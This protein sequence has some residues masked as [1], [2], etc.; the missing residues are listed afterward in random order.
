MTAQAVLAPT[1]LA[2]LTS[3]AIAHDGKVIPDDLTVDGLI[4]EL[5][6]QIQAVNKKDLVRCEAI[7]TAQAH[8]LDAIYNSMIRRALIQKKAQHIEMFFRVA[9]RA[10]S[11][12]RAT[13]EAISR[14]QNPPIAGYLN[15]TNIANNQQ[16]NN[17]APSARGNQNPQNKLLERALR[18]QR[19]RLDRHKSVGVN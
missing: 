7:L 6:K 3:F 19:K 8:T 5:R 4:A 17:G 18:D 10:Q 2:A 1:V 15:Q 9:L 13:V 11:Q 14:I 16:V 12:C